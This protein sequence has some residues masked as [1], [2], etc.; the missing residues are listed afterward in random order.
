MHATLIDFFD[1]YNGRETNSSST[2][3]AINNY[4]FFFNVRD[5][6]SEEDGADFILTNSVQSP[7]ED[8]RTLH[9][10]NSNYQFAV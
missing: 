9:G 1:K 7:P 4:K 5:D 6:P 8:I 2:N 3:N 10:I